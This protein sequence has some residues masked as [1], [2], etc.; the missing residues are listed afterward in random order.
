MQLGQSDDNDNKGHSSSLGSYSLLA[1]LA[2]RNNKYKYYSFGLT[3]STSLETSTLTITPPML[4]SINWVSVVDWFVLSIICRSGAT[5]LSVECSWASTVKIQLSV[6]CSPW[7]SW[8]IA[9]L[10]LNINHSNTNFIVLVWH[11]LP[12]SRRAR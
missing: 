2:E 11:H 10:A 6:L 7:Y 1:C 3:Q 9:E 12:H 5:S 8:K 4:F